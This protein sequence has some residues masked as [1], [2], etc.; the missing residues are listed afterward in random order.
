MLDEHGRAS[1]YRKY[2]VAIQLSLLE[3]SNL[4]SQ[5]MRYEIHLV[6][7]IDIWMLFWPE[8]VSYSVDILKLA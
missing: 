8:V 1:D 6:L 4:F 7:R 5:T 2:E 3:A